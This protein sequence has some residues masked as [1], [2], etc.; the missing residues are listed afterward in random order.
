MV[1]TSA[2]DFTFDTRRCTSATPTGGL[3]ARPA[4]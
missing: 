4:D 1:S 2:S 3:V